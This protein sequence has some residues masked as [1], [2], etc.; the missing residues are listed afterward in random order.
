MELL[1][2]GT[3]FG[4]EVDIKRRQAYRTPFSSF[5]HHLPRA[6]ATLPLAR[7]LCWVE[8]PNKQACSGSK[9]KKVKGILASADSKRVNANEHSSVINFIVIINKR[10]IATGVTL[11]KELRAINRLGII[12]TEGVEVIGCNETVREGV[13]RREKGLRI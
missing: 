3:C 11:S 1:R 5:P 2:T 4:L 10:Q 6:S 8:C 12:T 7:H 13:G 9:K